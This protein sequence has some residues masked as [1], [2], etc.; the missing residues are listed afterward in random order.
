MK[1]IPLNK[2]FEL[3]NEDENSVY[4]KKPDGSLLNVP[5]SSVID[6]DSIDPRSSLPRFQIVRMNDGTYQEFGSR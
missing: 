2:T 1:V 4:L 6:Y 5:R 3:V